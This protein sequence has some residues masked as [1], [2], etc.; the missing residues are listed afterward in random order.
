MDGNI[1]IGMWGPPGSGKSAYITMLQFAERN[2]WNFRPRGVETHDIYLDYTDCLRDRLEF[3]PATVG[4]LGGDVHLL[5]F[6]FEYEGNIIERNAPKRIPFIRRPKLIHIVI[7]E[8]AGE[9][10]E[11]PKSAPKLLID[12]M[13]VSKGI[14]WLVDPIQIDNPVDGRKSYRRMIQEWLL[15]LN[16]QRQSGKLDQYFAFCLTKMDDPDHVER[17]EDPENYCLEKLGPDVIRYLED[18]C[19]PRNIEFFGT[20]AAGFDEATGNST[21]DPDDPRR[22]MYPANPYGLFEPFDWLFK[23]LVNA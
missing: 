9:Y 18:F 22:L 11:N 23:K 17:I 16:E 6:D 10:Y 8:C 19:D 20:S 14:I 7:P 1:Q 2:G 4:G 21:V 3:V 5:E 15:I 12:T 13:K